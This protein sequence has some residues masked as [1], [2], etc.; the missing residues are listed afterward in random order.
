VCASASFT[1]TIVQAEQEAAEQNAAAAP[2]SAQAYEDAYEGLLSHGFQQDDIK[3]AL[4][5]LNTP[6]LDVAL[7]W[8]CLNVPP[9]RLPK[10]FAGARA[11]LCRV[12]KRHNTLS[13]AASASL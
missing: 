5:A 11:M 3:A 10:R 1:I 2:G 7:D 13:H 6:Q 4:L 8:L 9:G 12:Q